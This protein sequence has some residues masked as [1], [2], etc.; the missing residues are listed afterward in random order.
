MIMLNGYKFDGFYVDDDLEGKMVL[1]KGEVYSRYGSNVNEVLRDNCGDMVEEMLSEGMSE[2]EVENELDEMGYE[3][4]FVNEKYVELVMLG[5]SYGLVIG[6]C[7]VDKNECKKMGEVYW[8][9][10]MKG[11]KKNGYDELVKWL[12]G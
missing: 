4:G 1:S 8:N 6:K 2:D 3:V 12:E 5:D 11:G 9:G 10:V 7:E